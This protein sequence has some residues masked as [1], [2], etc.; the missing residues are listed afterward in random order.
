MKNVI[1]K[2]LGIAFLL[3][4]S[5]TATSAQKTALVDMEYILSNIP[6]Y[7]T[8]NQQLEAQSK[9]WQAEVTKLENEAGALYKKFQAEASRLSP[10]LRKVEEEAIIA[11][12]KEAYELKRRYFGPEGELVKKRENLMKPIQTEVWNSL[13]DL[14]LAHGLQIIIDKASGKIVYAD[15]NADISALVLQK[16]GYRN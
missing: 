9:K 12:E 8:M 7:T 16:M 5:V 6:A 4:L 10:E 15:P 13:K 3:F 2:L 14:A 1:K 11:K